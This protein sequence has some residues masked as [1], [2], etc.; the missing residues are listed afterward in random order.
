M[1]ELGDEESKDGSSWGQVAWGCYRQ[2]I[3]LQPQAL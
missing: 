2:D 3:L 1:E